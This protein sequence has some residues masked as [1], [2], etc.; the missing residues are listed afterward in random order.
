MIPGVDVYSGYGRIDW[1]AVAASGVRFAWIKSAEGNEPARDDSAFRRN[2]D[3]AQEAG[4][5]VGAYFFPYPLPYGPGLPAGRSPLEQAERAFRVCAGLGSQHGELSPCVDAE[6]PPP[7]EWVKWGCSAA[8]ISEWLH[9]YCEA[10]TILWGRLPVIY[11]YPWWWKALSAADVSWAAQYPLWMASYTHN[12][13]GT[14]PIGKAPPVPAPWKDWAAWQYSANGSLQ[15]VPGI[16]ACPVDRDCIRDEDTLKRLTGHRA[17]EPEADTE[18]E[19]VPS[20]RPSTLQSRTVVDWPIVRGRVPL[21]R[22][23]LDLPDDDPP[24]D[25]A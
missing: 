19:L 25:A 10:A 13:P 7:E 22:H 9:D 1:K 21:G 14:P 4:V 5:I 23:A 3:D 12:G 8:Q 18:P 11:T 15:R 17:Y 24:D 2:V 6:W 16:P 20:V